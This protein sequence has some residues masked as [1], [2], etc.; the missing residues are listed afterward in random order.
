LL[1]F[2]GLLL[3]PLLAALL[4]AWR[5]LPAFQS[6]ATAPLATAPAVPVVQNEATA[7][8]SPAS[9]QTAPLEIADMPV[10][11]GAR[12][13]APEIPA[14]VIMPAPAMSPLP[15]P[16]NAID[17]SWTSWAVLTW[18]FGTLIVFSPTLLG[19]LSLWLL[20]RR[21]ERVRDEHWQGQLDQL[22][23]ELGVRR[24]VEMLNSPLRTMPMT[25]GLW[26]T[27]LLLPE[28]AE[29]W[30]SEQRRAVLLHELGHVKRRD[31]LTQII[32]Q[33]GCALYWFN[34]LVWIGWRRLQVERERACD[35]LVLNSG[36]TA[37]SY[38][39]HL[40]DSAATM[41]QFRFVG[42]AVAMART[43]TLEER[44]RA[45][46]DGR[47]N[48]RS[49]S[50]V[51]VAI[52]GMLLLM[53]LVP[54]AVLRAQQ[55]P[56]G[57]P[58]APAAPAAPSTPATPDAPGT[59]AAPVDASY[60]TI[61]ERMRIRRLQEREAAAG[62]AATRPAPIAARSGRRGAATD[63][64][65]TPT[66]GEGPTITLD[67]T[68]YDVRI[69]ADQ[70]T[71]VDLEALT[72]AAQGNLVAG[73]PSKA[74]LDLIRT[75][76]VNAEAAV[77]AYEKQHPGMK[78]DAVYQERLRTF[79]AQYAQ[80]QSD[81]LALRTDPA[82]G[83]GHPRVQ[84]AVNREEQLYNNY[85]EEI[86]RALRAFSEQADYIKLVAAR[87]M[88]QLAVAAMEK[89]AATSGNQTTDGFEK[90]LTELGTFKPLYRANQSVR[91]AGDT[92]NIGSNT[93]YV[94]S[95]RTLNSGQVVN[96][97]QYANTGA[98]FNI[99]GRSTGADSV[100][101]DMRVEVSALFEGKT[102][103]APGVKAPI[104]RTA[105]MSHKGMAKSRQPFVIVSV[106]AASV[107]ADGKAVAYIARVTVGTPQSPAGSNAPP[108]LPRAPGE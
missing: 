78:L 56:T 27:R 34:P 39:K 41:T 77:L 62:Q 6:T 66:V 31:C 55:T 50:R 46:L 61:E 24:D 108:P 23:C 35:D 5:V 2:V 45:I 82:I 42:A 81:T 48:R 79:A 105:T 87:D 9:I 19:Y 51:G 14:A 10:A 98:I 89:Q 63:W 97:V 26:R 107:D 67:A 65:I 11:T 85:Q 20:T 68:I 58:A 106:D 103:V 60:E 22:R 30:P 32:V 52:M 18:M 8:P 64:T 28:Q 104:F 94:A 53:A 102:E 71:K 12:P 4:P 37:S 93:P 21:C 99:A 100:E 90:A 91:L 16:R 59:P 13:I 1:G 70:V 36:A 33:L 7:S 83:A 38:A 40:L 86:G 17:L 3:L 88:K 15:P 96:T 73:K 92:V 74:E 47:R 80:A 84:A 49:M 57:Q 95:A 75:E 54:V 69:P 101:L 25:W 43:S 76:Y 29:T 72:R 44:L